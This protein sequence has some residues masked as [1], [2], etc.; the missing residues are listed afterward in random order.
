MP[1]WRGLTGRAMSRKPPAFRAVTVPLS[2]A[3]VEI[4]TPSGRSVGAVP[5]PVGAA[6]PRSGLG[7]AGGGAAGF[8]AGFA[9]DGGGEGGCA[10]V[11]FD[12]G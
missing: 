5:V 9:P 11:G 2:P 12:P 4:A 6:T 3:P 7:R 10:P 8:D 1:A